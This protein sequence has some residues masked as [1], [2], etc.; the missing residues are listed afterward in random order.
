MLACILTAFKFALQSIQ[1]DDVP[2]GAPTWIA[3]AMLDEPH[4]HRIQPAATK[5]ASTEA[6]Y[7]LYL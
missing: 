2:H 6:F 7:F 3:D 5:K 1:V 4:P